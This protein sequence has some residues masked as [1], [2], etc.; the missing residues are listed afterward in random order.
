MQDLNML[1]CTEG[2]ERTIAEYEI[3]FMKAGFTEVLG[4][5]TGS[6]LDAILARK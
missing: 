4:C 2:R 6:P 3:L 5:R 1:T